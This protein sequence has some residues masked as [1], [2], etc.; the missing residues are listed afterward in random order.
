MFW[1]IALDLEGFATHALRRALRRNFAFALM[2][3]R[4]FGS[5]RALHGPP[6]TPTASLLHVLH[7]SA[8]HQELGLL[9]LRMPVRCQ[10]LAQ[11]A[12]HVA[13]RTVETQRER[14]ACRPLTPFRLPF[15]P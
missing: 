11:P 2:H 8:S 9:T 6:D 1:W 7:Q 3:T 14:P 13:W 10:L 15:A 5:A 4:Q 12:D